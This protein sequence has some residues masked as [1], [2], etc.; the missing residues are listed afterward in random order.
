M[1]RERRKRMEGEKTEEERGGKNSEK[2][3]RMRRGRDE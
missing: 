1:G 3:E 2:S